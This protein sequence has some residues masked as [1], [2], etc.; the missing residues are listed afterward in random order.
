MFGFCNSCCVFVQTVIY[1]QLLRSGDDTKRLK[2]AVMRLLRFSVSMLYLKKKS[3]VIAKRIEISWTSIYFSLKICHKYACG[4]AQNFNS[5][6][7]KFDTTE[8]VGYFPQQILKKIGQYIFLLTKWSSTMVQGQSI[9]F[10]KSIVFNK[11]TWNPLV[12]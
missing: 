9:S 5:T 2:S 11:L 3:N 7:T 12:I 6:R 8:N 10:N 1:H 4:L